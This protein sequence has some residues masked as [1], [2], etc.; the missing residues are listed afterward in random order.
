MKKQYIITALQRLKDN[1]AIHN[2]FMELGLDAS[3]F[4]DR[5]G[6]ISLIEEAIA[7]MIANDDDKV[8]EDVLERINWWLDENVTKIIWPNNRQYHYDVKDCSEFVNWLFTHY[9][10]EE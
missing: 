2:Q 5:T 6:Y 10:A 7:T 4:F 9:G 8:F 3:V 1:Q